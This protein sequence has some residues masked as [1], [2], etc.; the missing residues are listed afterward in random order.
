MK[1][2]L[3]T[4]IALVIGAGI[5]YFISAKQNGMHMQINSAQQEAQEKA[6]AYQK[7]QQDMMKQLGQ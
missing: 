3:T 7:Q 6:N 1:L 5:W 2:L 4:L